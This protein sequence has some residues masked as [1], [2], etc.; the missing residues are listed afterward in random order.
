LVITGNLIGGTTPTNDLTLTVIDID[1]DG[2]ILKVI[3][4]GN[5]NDTT[6]SYYLKA[7]NQTE[8]MLYED[9]MFT[10]PVSGLTLPYSG[11]VSTTVASISSPNIT[12][13]SGTNF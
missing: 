4:Q 12:L 7:I 11:I 13:T 5:P 8:F 1:T 9:N 3:C 2:E 10:I 6:N